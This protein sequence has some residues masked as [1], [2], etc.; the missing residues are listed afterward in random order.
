VPDDESFTPHHDDEPAGAR[1]PPSQAVKDSPPP[2]S[3][4]LRQRSMARLR[5]V[6][7]PGMVRDLAEKN[8]I[9]AMGDFVSHCMPNGR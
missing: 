1:T 5:P 2:S 8:A 9:R 6:S 7:I 3:R 4:P